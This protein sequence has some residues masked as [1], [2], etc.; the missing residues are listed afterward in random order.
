MRNMFMYRN[1]YN[2]GENYKDFS[3][4]I[5]T[6]YCKIFYSVLA[7]YSLTIRPLV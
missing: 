6:K 4:S 2:I 3:N 5:S 1:K 7:Q